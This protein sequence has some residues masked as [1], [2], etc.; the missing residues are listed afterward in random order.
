MTVYL[1]CPLSTA[2]VD[3]SQMQQF[4][5]L[6]TINSRYVFGDEIVDNKL[7]FEFLHKLRAVASVFH[8]AQDYV[9]I[10][11]DHVQFAYLVAILGAEHGVVKVLR[12]D[13][14][15]RGYVPITLKMW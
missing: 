4:G 6:E 12:W 13:R 11:G 8:P 5:N 9:L 14:P 1:V 10:G 15:A 2:N 7:P 3:M